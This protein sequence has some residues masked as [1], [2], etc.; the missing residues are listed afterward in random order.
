M[1]IRSIAF[2]SGPDESGP[3]SKRFAKFV[4]PTSVAERLECGASAPL[5]RD[6]AFAF[7]TLPRYGCPD[8]SVVK[9][10]YLENHA[11]FAEQVIRQFLSAH[12]VTVVPSL[13]AARSAFASGSFDVVFSDYDLDDGKGDEFVRECRAKYPSLPIVAVS[14]HDDGNA[15]LMAAGAS[16]V[17]GKMEFNRIQ[18][19][20]AR[21]FR[22]A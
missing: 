4:Q 11:V 19:V 1:L 14:S 7:L 21:L 18:Q 17:C 5:C 3:H 10:L 15:A 8:V 9:I 2:E 13:S 16:V 20:L 12:R 6:P 22:E